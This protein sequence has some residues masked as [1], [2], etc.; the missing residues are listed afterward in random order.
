MIK[1]FYDLDKRSDEI[2]KNCKNSIQ[3]RNLRRCVTEFC[4]QNS[5]DEGGIFD[6]DFFDRI[7][8]TKD[9][10]EQMCD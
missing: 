4:F 5:V 2:V 3:A 6:E 7:C 9:P 10:E 8:D 1:D